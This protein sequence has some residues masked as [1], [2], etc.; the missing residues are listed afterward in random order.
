MSFPSRKCELMLDCLFRSL[1]DKP[2]IYIFRLQ[3]LLRS[4]LTMHD[5]SWPWLS[6]TSDKVWRVSVVLC[7]TSRDGGFDQIPCGSNVSYSF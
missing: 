7:D 1:S 4:T 2:R 5:Y 3:T 6:H